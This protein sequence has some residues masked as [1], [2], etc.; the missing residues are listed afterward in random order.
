MRR[1]GHFQ[2]LDAM[3]MMT[4]PVPLLSRSPPFFLPA[5]VNLFN[6]VA[7]GKERGAWVQVFCTSYLKV[8]S[9]R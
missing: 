7:A 9:G 6:D 2:R 5:E 8:T 4:M 1:E 3:M